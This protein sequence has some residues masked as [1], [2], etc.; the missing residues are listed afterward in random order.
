MLNIHLW[1]TNQVLICGTQAIFCIDIYGAL[2]YTHYTFCGTLTTCIQWMVNAHLHLCYI[3][4]THFTSC[5]YSGTLV[6]QTTDPSSTLGNWYPPRPTPHPRK[7][8]TEPALVK[9]LSPGGSNNRLDSITDNG[10]GLTLKLLRSSRAGGQRRVDIILGLRVREL[11]PSL[12]Y[13]VQLPQSSVLSI[14]HL[15]ICL[16]RAHPTLVTPALDEEQPINQLTTGS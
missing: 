15:P 13:P 14:K 7:L 10:A 1:Y 16:V 12:E 5:P 2:N 4:C 6:H 11:Y 3:N 8:V 9:L